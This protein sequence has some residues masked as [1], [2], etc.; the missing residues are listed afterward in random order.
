MI[1][2]SL[3]RSG[4]RSEKALPNCALYK[5][6]VG[7]QRQ[8][9]KECVAKRKRCAASELEQTPS[10]VASAVSRKRRGFTLLHSLVPMRRP[11]GTA[12]V[13][14]AKAKDFRGGR[15]EERGEI[16]SSPSGGRVED[17]HSL[18]RSV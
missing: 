13:L 10:S 1:S 7:Q 9:L 6:G 17:E 2:V 15:N 16:A 3:A 12:A 8:P 18:S 11:G 4:E 14:S 5:G